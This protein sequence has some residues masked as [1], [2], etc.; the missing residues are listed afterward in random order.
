MLLLR[1]RFSEPARWRLD[2]RQVL[3]SGIMLLFLVPVVEIEVRVRVSEIERESEL[4]HE[5]QRV[6]G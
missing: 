4:L 2:T 3:V 5:R 1:L 6:N